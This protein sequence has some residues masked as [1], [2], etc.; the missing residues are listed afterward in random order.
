MKFINLKN[1]KIS[2]KLNIGIIGYG[3]Q[4]SNCALNLRDTGHNVCVHQI[5]NKN[6]KKLKKDKFKNY[7]LK[8]L[9]MI[10]EVIIILVPDASHHKVINKLKKIETKS[11]KVLILPSGYYCANENKNNLDKTNYIMIS[12]RYPGQILR[13][14]FLDGK[15]SLGFFASQKKLNLFERKIAFSVAK[16][17][18][19]KSL[20]LTTMKEELQVD[21]FIE[22]FMI[23]RLIGTIEASFNTLVKNG[24]HKH[25]AMFEVFQSG[26]ILD[27][28]KKG[29]KYGIF[30]SFKKHTSPTCQYGLVDKYSLVNKEANRNSRKIFKE[31]EN[32]IFFKKI[33]K[34][35]DNNYL[36]IKI[37][38]RNK[39]YSDF[40]KT[41][42]KLYDFMKKNKVSFL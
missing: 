33:K 42:K 7:K 22:N 31:V 13:K 1:F 9:Y 29:L 3:I 40:S 19:M 4:G 17:W 16:S 26:E 35:L 5:S 25:I 34:E 32:N 14:N 28:L 38:N 24:I 37:F 8:D 21:L 41:Q 11:K 12:P 30:N 18:G 15:S 39:K 23:P 2:K 36:N 10:S 6:L 27:L 20:F